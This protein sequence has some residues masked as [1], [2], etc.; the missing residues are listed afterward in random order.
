[1]EPVN[2]EAADIDPSVFGNL[3][4]TF[5]AAV[6]CYFSVDQL[7]AYQPTD[8]KEAAKLNHRVEYLKLFSIVIHNNWIKKYSAS[9][10]FDKR[11]ISQYQL[12]GK[13]PDLTSVFHPIKCE[14]RLVPF[15]YS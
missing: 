15:F 10:M 3:N 11:L 6:R 7:E 14:T 13:L 8:K 9:K 1:M 2:I 5:R 12:P 4:H